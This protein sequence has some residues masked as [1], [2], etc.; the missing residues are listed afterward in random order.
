MGFTEDYLE[1][2]PGRKALGLETRKLID[3]Y[4]AR[5]ITYDIAKEI[6]TFWGLNCGKYMFNGN[7]FNSTYALYSGK[8]RLH[9]VEQ[10]LPKH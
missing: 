8:K 5:K 2:P 1:L 3:D 9:I 7:E 6:V 4:L 10:M